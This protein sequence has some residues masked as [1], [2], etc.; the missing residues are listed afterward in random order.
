MRSRYCLTS[1]P[2]KKAPSIYRRSPKK[3]FSLTNQNSP[4]QNMVSV[5]YENII[6]EEI[7]EEASTPKKSTQRN[8][9]TFSPKSP[10]TPYSPGYSETNNDQFQETSKSTTYNRSLKNRSTT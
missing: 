4:S 5:Q 9:T 6:S 7:I 3:K 2:L 1:S 8:T 10:Q